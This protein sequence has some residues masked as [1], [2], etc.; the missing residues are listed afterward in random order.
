M[1][2]KDFIVCS[3]LAMNYRSRDS[4]IV[5]QV[6]RGPAG[7]D[8]KILRIANI[9]FTAMYK[10]FVIRTFSDSDD[11]CINGLY[12]KLQS[13]QHFLEC[14][15]FNL[16][17]RVEYLEE[18]RK[19]IESKHKYSMLAVPG[20]CQLSRDLIENIARPLEV[21]DAASSSYYPSSA[22][23]HFY[24]FSSKDENALLT[25]AMMANLQLGTAIYN[26]ILSRIKV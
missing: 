14:E 19:A 22:H 26:K 9:T 16:G 1:D 20:S 10:K 6:A 15:S 23:I 3:H 11:P 5:E 17:R 7:H 2:I 21:Y 8:F 13:D 25:E 24:D 12:F 4:K 18:V